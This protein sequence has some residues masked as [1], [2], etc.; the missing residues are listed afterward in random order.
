MKLRNSLALCVAATIGAASAHAQRAAD[1]IEAHLAAAKKAAGIDFPGLLA[2]ICVAP[3][4]APTPDVRP[5]PAPPDRARW[6]MEPAKI[7]DDVYFVGTKDRS[8]WA[9]TTSDG[10]I[11]IDT[12]FE[13]EAEAV[14]VGGLKKL[15]FD[16]ASVKYVLISH[17]HPGEVGGAKLMQDRF[18]SRIVMG[19]GDWEM[20]EQSVNRFPNGK[21]R[22]DIVVMDGQK[23]TLGDRTV[24]LLLM[25]GHTPGT[26]SM[27][28]QVKD[29]G[30][31]LTVAF[32]GGTEF[33]FVNDVP[34]FDTYINSARKF[35]A[36]AA[37]A[38]ATVLMTNQSEFDNAASKIR[39]LAGRRP[40]EPHPFE[41]GSDG[42]QRY[43]KVFDECA[44]VA[45]LKLL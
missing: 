39:M 18:G 28:F 29:H 41:V 26:V 22:R 7:F 8:S 23:I 35:A 2:A 21:P 5:A 43:F 12:T 24:T 36:A 1:T 4:N 14:I 42:V 40:G 32:S 20:I 13:Y 31:P 15:G 33:N 38:G 6:Y 27:I 19:E 9:L 16:P 25:P 45:R 37:A 3:R 17:A 10:I 44:Q 34:H 30:T 11:L